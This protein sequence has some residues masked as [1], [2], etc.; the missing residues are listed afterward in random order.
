MAIPRTI[1]YG[2]HDTEVLRRRW[3]PA[4]KT[5]YRKTYV[6]KPGDKWTEA[7]ITEKQ[8]ECYV[9]EPDGGFVPVGA[10]I[11]Q[12]L[13]AEGATQAAFVELWGGCVLV[14]HTLTCVAPTGRILEILEMVRQK[15]EGK[16]AGFGQQAHR[17]HG[18]RLGVRDIG[19]SWKLG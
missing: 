12:D 4:P 1:R 11:S 18:E 17:H 9:T 7:P 14:D 6:L 2:S 13:I 16:L 3:I 10:K 8:W 19:S 15:N 5:P